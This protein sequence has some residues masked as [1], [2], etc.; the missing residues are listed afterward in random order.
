MARSQSAFTLLEVLLVI[1]L[2]ALLTGVLV[3]GGAQLVR[4]KD[5]TPEEIFWRAVTEARNFALLHQ[6]EVHLAYDREE[7]AFR[8]RTPQG[9]EVFPVPFE[10]DLQ[11]DF[12]SAQAAGRSVLIGGTLVE[13]QPLEAVTF[14]ED[15]TC[16]PF[17]V[18]LRV[19][20]GAAQ[21]L[22]IDPWTC[23]PVLSRGEGGG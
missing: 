6:C 5:L 23:A 18:Q 21:V 15:G 20:A 12:L 13:T 14:F 1:A 2:I 19:G 17:R 22:E 7:R 3:V 16:T 8:A 9:G 10:G 4:P 11:I